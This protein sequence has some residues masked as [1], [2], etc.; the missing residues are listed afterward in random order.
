MHF[1]NMNRANL[2]YF[3]N[4]IAKNG[5]ITR[6]ADYDNE[7]SQARVILQ[8]TL[9]LLECKWKIHRKFLLTYL[10]KFNPFVEVSS[11]TTRH[12]YY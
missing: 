6:S 4:L 5:K 10:G 11:V 1:T 8:A 3:R 9:R 7:K 2:K 12:V